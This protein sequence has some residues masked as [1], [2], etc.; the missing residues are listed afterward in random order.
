MEVK[1]KC[2]E[3]IEQ[4]QMVKAQGQDGVM[5]FVEEKGQAGNISQNLKEK[6]IIETLWLKRILSR[7]MIEVLAEALVAEA[8]L[9]G[10]AEAEAGVVVGEI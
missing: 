2:Q 1:I 10:M 9:E 7:N 5:G 6:W 3:E 4:V 8:F